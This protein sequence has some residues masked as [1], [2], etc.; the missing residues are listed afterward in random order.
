MLDVGNYVFGRQTKISAKNLGHQS[1]RVEFV[2][3]GINFCIVERAVEKQPSFLFPFVAML[4]VDSN[5]FLFAFV[6]Y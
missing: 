1:A 2:L 5:R 4:D 3:N 6:S